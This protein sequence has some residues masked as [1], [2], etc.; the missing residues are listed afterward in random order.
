MRAFDDATQEE[1]E[2]ACRIAG[3]DPARAKLRRSPPRRDL[4]E[5]IVR[6]VEVTTPTPMIPPALE[7]V[8]FLG[9]AKTR[10]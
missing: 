9:Y 1:I 3:W 2:A 8:P 7:G 10:Y 5:E 4:L 6:E